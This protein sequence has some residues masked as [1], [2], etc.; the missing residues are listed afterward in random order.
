MRVNVTL[1]GGAFG[2]RLGID[3]ALEA[4]EVSRAAKAP[5]LLLWTREDDT[6]HGFFQPASAH[7]VRGGLDASGRLVAWTHTKAGYLQNLFG[8]PPADQL[9]DP[10]F[11]RI[12]SWGV[13]DIPYSIPNVETGYVELEAPIPNG[14]WRLRIRRRHP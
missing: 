6:R 11:W 2:R 9:A 4:V 13:Y 14:P 12:P 5:V 8:R 3:Y 1:L 7:W 10:N